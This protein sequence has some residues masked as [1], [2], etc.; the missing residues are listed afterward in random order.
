V[1]IASAEVRAGR[2]AR[3]GEMLMAA[4][5]RGRSRRDRFIRRTS[6]ARIMVEAGLFPVAI[7]ML[8]QLL[9]EIDEFKL[10][11]WEAGAVVATPMSLLWRCYDRTDQHDAR[12][13]L[14]LRICQL[15]PVQAIALTPQGG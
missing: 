8:E 1:E 7:P 4:A 14:Y 6:V 15:D 11:D 13:P 5:S 2:P 12:E 3:A 9:A 10:E